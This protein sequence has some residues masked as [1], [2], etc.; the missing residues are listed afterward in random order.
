ME[1]IRNYIE[2]IFS[3]LPKTKEIIEMKLNMLDNMEEKYNALLSEG[4]TEHEAVGMIIS[5]IGSIEELKNELGITEEETKQQEEIQELNPDEVTAL[6]KEYFEFRKKYGLFTTISIILFVLSPLLIIVLTRLGFEIIS[7]MGF[8]GFVAAGVG[9]LVYINHID[10]NYKD[11]LG[12]TNFSH[13]CEN[14][15]PWKRG[16]KYDA[17][18]G[19]I[20]V[21]TVAIYLTLGFFFGLWHPGWIVFL[22]ATVVQMYMEF[23][24]KANYERNIQEK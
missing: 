7:F 13:Y 19:I 6:R 9:I 18:S 12:I 2:G 11:M 14:K 16:S 3:G 10:A 8:F 17:F 15:E 1:L 21:V 5:Q 22:L 24:A 23:K 20:W 4:N